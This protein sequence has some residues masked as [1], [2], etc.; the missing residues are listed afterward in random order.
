MGQGERKIREFLDGTPASYCVMQ[1]FFI[2]KRPG[3]S[4]GRSGTT[5]RE[6]SE[7][8]AGAGGGGGFGGLVHENPV[9]NGP[10]ILMGGND[11]VW[12]FWGDCPFNIFVLPFSSYR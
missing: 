9:F 10:Q 8:K 2:K 3:V 12:V 11:F 5:K 6:E 7:Q 4:P 1:K